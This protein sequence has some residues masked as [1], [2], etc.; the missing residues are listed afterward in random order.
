MNNKYVGVKPGIKVTYNNQN[1][2]VLSYVD[3]DYVLCKPFGNN[4]TEKI[5]IK[6]LSMPDIQSTQDLSKMKDREWQ[7]VQKRFTAIEPLIYGT[8]SRTVEAV[9]KRAKE[10]NVSV[11]TLY[12]WIKVYLST[13][14]VSALIPKTRTDK[15]FVR[16][17]LEVQAVIDYYVRKDYLTVKKK[18]L[19]SKI[20]NKITLKC[21]L[22]GIKVPHPNT[23][24]NYIN[25]LD[26]EPIDEAS[27]DDIV[28]EGVGKQSS[29][30]AG[31]G[32]AQQQQ[33]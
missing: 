30:I 20:I 33:Y 4:G 24:R 16:I 17:P 31:Y 23:I 21:Q 15:G 3:S 22:K 10:F 13:G 12:R 11:A 18:P 1:Y 32:L 14:L 9:E 2:M 8:T 6:S 19:I 29:Q 28:I 25:K 27:N 7:L 26:S 5:L